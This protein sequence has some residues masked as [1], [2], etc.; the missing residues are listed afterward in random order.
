[1]ADERVNSFVENIRKRNEI[2]AEILGATEVRL[3]GGRY[4][5]RDGSLKSLRARLSARDNDIKQFIYDFTEKTPRDKMSDELKALIGIREESGTSL[6]RP[7]IRQHLEPIENLE[8][9]LKE[10]DNDLNSDKSE[11]EKARI[12]EEYDK[13]AKELEDRRKRLGKKWETKLKID[14]IT[15]RINELNK[16]LKADDVPHYRRLK[17]ELAL[18]KSQLKELSSEYMNIL[19]DIATEMGKAMQKDVE[20]EDEGRDSGGNRGKE[21]EGER[22]TD[23]EELPS[24][25]EPIVPSARGEAGGDSYPAV[26]PSRL[27]DKSLSRRE[28]RKQKRQDKRELK[29]ALKTMRKKYR[30]E[31]DDYDEGTCDPRFFD[32]FDEE[33]KNVNTEN[34]TKEDKANRKK[35]IYLRDNCYLGNQRPAKVVKMILGKHSHDEIVDMVKN[36]KEA[37]SAVELEL[38]LQDKIN[39]KDYSEKVG[40]RN[41]NNHGELD[42]Y[43]DDYDDDYEDE[44]IP[45]RRRGFSLGLEDDSRDKEESRL[46][47]EEN[48]D[49]DEDEEPPVPVFDRSRKREVS[50]TPKERRKELEK[51]IAEGGVLEVHKIKELK[52]FDIKNLDA[53]IYL[54][55]GRNGKEVPIPYVSRKEYFD[56]S[57]HSILNGIGAQKIPIGREKKMF[58]EW[59]DNIKGKFDKAQNI[60]RNPGKNSKNKSVGELE[61]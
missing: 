38:L 46:A 15:K 39:G 31:Y 35:V 47:K 51:E 23:G 25:R 11:E 5:N 32:M 16:L 19:N 4:T 34:I 14:K 54:A 52:N 56:P 55:D 33:L 58:V 41:T 40:L 61:K 3:H 50:V 44:D 59:T 22:D 60:R 26:T 48:K 28:E 6:V 36:I 29:K 1:M 57:E 9:E 2:Y 7:T 17:R 37:K 18:L 49:K 30:N 43:Y 24:G 42:D 8:N 20:K 27:P 45:R 10:M 21:N 53:F 12:K 13:K